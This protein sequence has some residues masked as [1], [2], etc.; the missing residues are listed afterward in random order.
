MKT[1]QT[2][3]PLIEVEAGLGERIWDEMLA[4]FLTLYRSLHFGVL[5]TPQNAYADV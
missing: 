1:A 5:P 3:G 2:K 4:P